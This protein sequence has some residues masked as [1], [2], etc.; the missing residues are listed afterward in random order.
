MHVAGPSDAKLTAANLTAGQNFDSGAVCANNQ[1]AFV[2]IN[3]D[4]PLPSR[5]TINVRHPLLCQ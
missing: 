5:A 2:Y 3:S 4:C 1:R